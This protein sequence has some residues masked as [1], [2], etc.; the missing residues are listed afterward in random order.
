MQEE[1]VKRAMVGCGGWVQLLLSSTLLRD[2]DRVGKQDGIGAL[3]I[4][5][6]CWLGRKFGYFNLMEDCSAKIDSQ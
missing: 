2:E 3:L 1:R 6:E 4:C 5:G